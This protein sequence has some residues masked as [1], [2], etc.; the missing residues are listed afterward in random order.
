MRGSVLASTSFAVIVGVMSGAWS[1]AQTRGLSRADLGV[2]LVTLKD[3]VRLRGS[4]VGKDGPDTLLIAVSR[5]WLAGASPA[6]YAQFV[7]KERLTQQ[8]TYA[9][10]LTRIDEWQ[11]A[12]PDEPGLAF[13][14][15]SE[16][17]RIAELADQWKAG[18][19]SVDLQFLL[20]PLPA[21]QVARVFQQPASRKRIVLLAWR[22]QLTSPETR[23]VTDLGRELREHGVDI[24]NEP[25]D[26]VG[27]AAGPY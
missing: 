2:D 26:P 6:H 16:R 8:Q 4:I 3:G 27:S 19:T 9:T 15:N 21:E 23:S 14:L 13:F 7:E 17:K 20:I 24:A 10:I 18:T 12:R 25:I 5:K 22:E 1:L 11:E